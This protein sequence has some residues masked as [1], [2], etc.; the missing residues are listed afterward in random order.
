[1]DVAQ[2]KK[3]EGRV[4]DT[5]ERVLLYVILGIAGVVGVFILLLKLGIF[6]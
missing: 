4:D 5:P 3:Q 6:R 2:S 1:M